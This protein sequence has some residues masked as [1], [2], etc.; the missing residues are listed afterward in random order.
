MT[1]PQ[2]SILVIEDDQSLNALLCDHIREMGYTANGVHSLAEAESQ[3][4][5]LHPDLICAD[6]RLP[7]SEG[8]TL[9]ER[10]SP[11]CPV[12]ILTAF[13]SIDQAVR[14]VQ[15]GASDYLTKPVTFDTLKL[16]LQRALA[17]AELKRDVVFWQSLARRGSG[18]PI[19]G[20]SPNVT[21]LRRLIDLYAASAPTLLIEGEGGVGKELVARA[22]HEGSERKEERFVPID[23]DPAQQTMTA[24]ELFGHEPDAIP[25]AENRRE[26]MLELADGGTIY[27]SDVAELSPANQ[28][29]LLRVMETG[30]FRRLGG[31]QNLFADVRIIAATSN[32]LAKLVEEGTFRSELYYRLSA[33]RIPVPPL[34]E[35]KEDI[36]VL[37]RYFVRNRSFQRNIDKELTAQALQDLTTYDWPGNVRELRNVIERGLIMSATEPEIAPHHIALT[38]AAARSDAGVTLSFREEPTLD[39]IRDVYLKMLLDRHDGNRKTVARIMGMSERNTYRLIGKLKET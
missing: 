34:R 33:F 8:F 16:A 7:D 13:G 31:V 12:I 9:L 5:A 20:D 29:R 14:A 3:A 38:P 19:I 23:C 30:V 36:P 17:T 27:I 15:S 22:L 21:E 26:G 25:G 35:R 37:A 18:E 2:H 11:H 1:Q 6:I 28:S 10:F 32:D 24:S 39:Q 4:E